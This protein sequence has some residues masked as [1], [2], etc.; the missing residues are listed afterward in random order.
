ML[1]QYN[2]KKHLDNIC[3]GLCLIDNQTLIYT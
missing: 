3:V 1:Y 2:K